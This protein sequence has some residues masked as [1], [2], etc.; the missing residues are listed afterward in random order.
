MNTMANSETWKAVRIKIY[1]ILR[2]GIK[3]MEGDES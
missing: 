1:I 3:E 2:L